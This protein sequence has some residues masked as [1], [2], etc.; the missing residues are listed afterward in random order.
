MSENKKILSIDAETNGLYGDAF[1]I[2]AILMDKET[3]KEEKRLLARCPIEVCV[4][5]FVKDNVLPELEDVRFTNINYECM[6]RDFVTFFMVNKGDADVIV[7][8]GCPVEARLFIDAVNMELMGPF[9][10]PYP[11]VDIAACPQIW[12]S[13]D[14]Y[15]KKNGIEVP[16]C[17]G[18]THNPLYDCYAAALAYRHVLGFK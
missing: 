16:D 4:D 12:D 13:V 8:M 7:H 15:N 17:N 14:G 5:K 18:G 1:A 11:L 9:D 10:G 6:L 2:G 3:G